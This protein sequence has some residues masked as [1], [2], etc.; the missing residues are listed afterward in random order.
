VSSPTG[1][2]IVRRLLTIALAGA[3]MI[4]L[5]GSPATARVQRTINTF[6]SFDPATQSHPGA[7]SQSTLDVAQAVHDLSANGVLGEYA[8]LVGVNATGQAL[9]SQMGAT[10]VVARVA[11][12]TTT[13]NHGCT[14]DGIIFPTGSRT[15]TAGETVAVPL[16]ASLRGQLCTG[17]TSGCRL[18]VLT[19]HTVFPTNCWNLDQGTVRVSVY[20]HVRVKPKPRIAK[21]SASFSTA[22]G[23]SSAGTSTVTLAN[24]PSASAPATFELAGKRYGPV[25][26]G[27]SLHVTVALQTA[28]AVEIKVTSGGETL[29][30]G[31]V[32]ADP[33]SSSTTTTA[34][35]S[36]SAQFSCL[37]GGVVVTLTD[38]ASAT[39][40]ATFTINGTSYG[41][42]SP[43]AT[44]SVTVPVAK[45]A[46]G[47]VTVQ[48]GAATLLTTSAY[49]N[50][51]TAGL[52]ASALI[53]CSL[54]GGT[55]DQGTSTIALTLSNGSP[56]PL[57]ATF[58]VTVTG[59][60]LTG[61]GPLSAGPI[62]PGASETLLIPADASGNPITVTA[63]SGSYSYAPAAFTRSCPQGEE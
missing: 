17:L 59:N 11:Q 45:G 37:A 60:T 12:T 29:V 22:C 15:L 9:V 51:C 56:D 32:P 21:P 27:R 16:P 55:F 2:S 61:Y 46:S 14:T 53:S 48:S 26:A 35:P 33:C 20:L 7:C 36:A 38:A 40:P 50:S 57:P 5:T 6:R 10:L 30:D 52:N 4:A 28:S 23:S 18:T 34:L 1:V 49:T 39:A 58:T 47:S 8:A 13:A 63:T 31:S 19:F 43:G 41:P 62:A 44:E 42:L 54:V 3:A 24:A 25:A